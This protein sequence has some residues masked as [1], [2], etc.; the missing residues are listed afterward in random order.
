[1][2][3][4]DPSVSIMFEAALAELDIFELILLD[5]V[6]PK[7]FKSDVDGAALGAFTAVCKLANDAFVVLKWWFGL[8]LLKSF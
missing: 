3:S 1:M 5:N 6:P 4:M 2:L 8:L 7:S